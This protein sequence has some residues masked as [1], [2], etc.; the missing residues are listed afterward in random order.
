MNR[1]VVVLLTVF[2]MSSVQADE[3]KWIPYFSNR[4]TSGVKKEWGL[5]LTPRLKEKNHEAHV[6]AE[7]E[8][9]IFHFFDVTL[10]NNA[11]KTI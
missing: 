6:K 8:K 9:F 11:N 1:L 10:K 4:Y 7:V 2:M 3:G 5:S